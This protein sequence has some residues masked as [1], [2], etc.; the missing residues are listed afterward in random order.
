M[1]FQ[2]DI[3][4]LDKFQIMYEIF[5]DKNNKVI[6]TGKFFLQILS[7]V[8]K[9]IHYIILIKKKMKAIMIK[10]EKVFKKH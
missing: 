6:E 1:D 9:I 4:K 7:L 10:M 8:D 3:R 5:T 2:R